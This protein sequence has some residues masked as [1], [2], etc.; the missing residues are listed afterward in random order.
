MDSFSS[1]DIEK[2]IEK[3]GNIRRLGNYYIF[4]INP[5]C[6]I[7]EKIPLACGAMDTALCAFSQHWFWGIPQFNLCYI[8]L[9]L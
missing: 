6:A 3:D 4:L 1:K 9:Q 5:G 7:R 8:F 2:N